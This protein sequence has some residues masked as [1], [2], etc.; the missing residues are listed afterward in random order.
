MENRNER[1]G[2]GDASEDRGPG[3]TPLASLGPSDQGA[4]VPIAREEI[5][6]H[7]NNIIRCI[8][9]Q[10]DETGTERHT[11]DALYRI[12]AFMKRYGL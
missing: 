4:N 10:H 8:V 1:K 6:A 11:N 5:A 12:D 3:Q 9:R 2:E 7:L